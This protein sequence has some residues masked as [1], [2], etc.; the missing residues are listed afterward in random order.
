[1]PDPCFPLD[2]EGHGVHSFK[3]MPDVSDTKQLSCSNNG[4]KLNMLK[5]DIPWF[6]SV[7]WSDLVR[8]RMIRKYI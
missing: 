1:V 4:C 6:A 8:V 7:D 3:M 5:H 2:K